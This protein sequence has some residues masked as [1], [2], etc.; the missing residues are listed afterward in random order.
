MVRIPRFAHPEPQSQARYEREVAVN[1]DQ[2]AIGTE[3]AAPDRL[4]QQVLPPEQRHFLALLELPMLQ[5]H[6][7]HQLPRP[8]L[9]DADWITS[10]ASESKATK[11]APRAAWPGGEPPG[12]ESVQ[13][14]WFAGLD[15]VVSL[16]A[17]GPPTSWSTSDRC[18]LALLHEVEGRPAGSHH[19]ATA[20]GQE[21]Q[22]LQH[23]QRKSQ[24][25]EGGDAQLCLDQERQQQ[26]NR[27]LEG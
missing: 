23:Q 17:L 16:C 2:G 5:R 24:G 12:S 6:R 22:G 11:A 20:E 18:R 4:R 10:A 27:G 25:R 13:G 7:D 21:H 8:A 15:S 19:Q 3:L 9:S 14:S 1:V 26:E